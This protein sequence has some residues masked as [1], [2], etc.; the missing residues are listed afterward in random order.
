[1]AVTDNQ[2]IDQ[3][4]LT[5]EELAE[6]MGAYKKEL[7]HLYKVSSA[8]RA[9]LA[10]RGGPGLSAMLRQCDEEMRADIDGLKRKYGIHY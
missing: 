7:A 2:D 1:M 3:E 5:P 10:R 9:L 4:E 6:L 8:K